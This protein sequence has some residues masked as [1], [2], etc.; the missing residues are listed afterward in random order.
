MKRK[1][2]EWV[3]TLRSL[4]KLARVLPHEAYCLLAKSVILSWR[5]AMRTMPVGS[6]VYQPLEEALVESFF[7]ACF[8]W[9]SLSEGTRMRAALP[10]RHGGLATPDPCELA[11]TER[12]NASWATWGLTQAILDQSW[13]HYVDKKELSKAR[14]ERQAAEDLR[15][16]E[17]AEGVL[18]RLEGREARSLKEARQRGGIAWLAAIPLEDSD[19]KL[20]RSSSTSEASSS[21]PTPSS[22]SSWPAAA[23][24]VSSKQ[25]ARRHVEVALT[26]AA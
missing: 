10:L 23:S 9:P 1:V 21:E 20:A 22:S 7:P 4:S 26:M 25:R 8:G 17:V 14:V 13:D 19:L 11:R 16:K 24:S 3:E 5:Y 15:L 18:L 2:V 6:D 12:R